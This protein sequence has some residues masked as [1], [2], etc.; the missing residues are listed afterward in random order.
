M[1]IESSNVYTKRE[2]TFGMS[3]LYTRST[4]I[5]LNK[6]DYGDLGVEY[7]VEVQ[8]SG[9]LPSE[10]YHGENFYAAYDAYDSLKANYK[11]MYE[12]L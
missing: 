11:M 12:A 10:R 9:H 3:T 8:V 4:T 2:A 6:V 7:I 5:R 1:N